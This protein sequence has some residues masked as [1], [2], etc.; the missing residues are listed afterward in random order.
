MFR[1]LLIVAAALMMSAPSRAQ[2][3]APSPAV[4]HGYQLGPGDRLRIT[5]YGETELTGEYD[6]AADGSLTFPL[7]G[8]VPAAQLTPDQLS[9][10][11]GERLREGFLREPQVS[12]AVIAYRPFYILGEVSRPGTYPFAPNLDV[13]S[14]VAVAGGYTYRANRGRVFIRRAGEADERPYSLRD[15]VDVRPG[16]TIRV[17]ERFF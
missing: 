14:A 2:V 13:M 8:A 16:D 15:R 5:V 3:A 6:V 11:I 10:S 7:V 1:V 12:S 17:G 4:A 9:T